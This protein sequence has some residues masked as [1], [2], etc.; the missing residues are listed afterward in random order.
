L[1]FLFSG[2]LLPY[3]FSL[4]RGQTS[5]CFFPRQ[6]RGALHLTRAILAAVDLLWARKSDRRATSSA[7][8]SFR[9]AHRLA[10]YLVE[11]VQNAHP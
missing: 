10:Q 6:L 1:H 9:L 7:L 3:Q 4:S 11:F 2:A 8:L 5:R